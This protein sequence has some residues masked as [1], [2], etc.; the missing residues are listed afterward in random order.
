MGI[1]VQKYGGSSVATAEKIKAVARRIIETRQRGHAVV[2]VVSTFSL[3]LR[4]LSLRL[5]PPPARASDDAARTS[6]RD[7]RAAAP[8]GPD[9][10]GLATAG[11]QSGDRPEFSGHSPPSRH[12]DRPLT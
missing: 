6:R 3:S 4:I 10:F 1:I 12:R 11:L 2:V 7:A 5:T 9:P 8:V